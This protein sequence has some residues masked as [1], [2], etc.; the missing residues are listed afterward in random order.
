MTQMAIKKPIWKKFIVAQAGAGVNG[1]SLQHALPLDAFGITLAIPRLAYERYIDPKTS[2]GGAV[3]GFEVIGDKGR[4]VGTRPFPGDTVFLRQT[5]RGRRDPRRRPC[6]GQVLR[7]GARPG[8]RSGAAQGRA[9]DRHL[10]GPCRRRPRRGGR[11]HPAAAGERGP[12]DEDQSARRHGCDD[13]VSWLLLPIAV[14]RRATGSRGTGRTPRR[15][16]PARSR[17]TS[18]RPARPAAACI[19]SIRR[20]AGSCR[21]RRRV[22]LRQ[23]KAPAPDAAASCCIDA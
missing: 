16:G 19:S 5:A 15:R 4:E 22:S 3:R 14:R 9:G 1:L 21:R 18:P 23:I 6:P 17:P 10:D 20:P 2:R 11:V 8:G 7:H 13:D 12:F